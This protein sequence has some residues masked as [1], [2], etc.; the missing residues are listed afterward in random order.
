M[1]DLLDLNMENCWV[2]IENILW[3][4]NKPE[5]AQPLPLPTDIIDQGEEGGID[6]GGDGEFSE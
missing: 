1:V 5:V 6:G 2:K 3:E 4:G